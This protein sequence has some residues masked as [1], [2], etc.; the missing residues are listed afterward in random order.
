MKFALAIDLQRTDT[1]KPMT[2]VIDEVTELVQLA[3]AGGFESVWAAEHH[4]IEFT[5]GPNPFSLLLHWAHHTK[6]V[7]LG[8]AVVVAPYWHPIKLA[9]E[10]ALVDLLTGGR[11]E[12]GIGRGAYQH[13]FDRMAGGMPQEKG[14]DYMREMLPA[15]L[16]LWQGDYAHDGA[17]WKW[18]SS[19]AVPKPLQKPYPPIWIAARDPHSFDFAIKMGAHIMSNPLSKPFGEMHVLRAKYEKAVADN[20]DKP[21]PRWMVLRRACVYERAEDWRVPVESTMNYSR[22]FETLFKNLGGVKDGFPELADLKALANSVDFTPEAVR[23][24]LVFGTPDEVVKKLKM[25]EAVG[26]DV[27]LYG[28][29][30]GTPHEVSKRSL[31]LFIK[32]VMPHFA[33]AKGARVAAAQ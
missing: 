24:N 32:E 15:I 25:Y 30:F 2:K 21:K 3:D 31:E 7:R 26:T 20:P 1:S 27:F 29:S 11:L 4:T 14:G 8:T 5:I 17:L 6:S 23:E 9:S 22:R 10:S 33:K 28:L 12:F 13:E 16:K 19:T 18:P